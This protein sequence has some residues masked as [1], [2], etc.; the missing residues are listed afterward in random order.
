MMDKPSSVTA[1]SG[2]SDGIFSVREFCRKAEGNTYHKA[3][4]VNSLRIYKFLT[5][6]PGR[7]L[8]AKRIVKRLVCKI[9][10]DL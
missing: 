6:C 1:R 4:G 8:G 9:T 3:E 7:A 10:L 5:S 2:S